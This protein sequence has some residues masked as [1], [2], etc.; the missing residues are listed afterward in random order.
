MNLRYLCFPLAVLLVLFLT[1]QNCIFSENKVSF[2]SVLKI[3]HF[4]GNGD[5][6]DGK[7]DPGDYVRTNPNLD[8]EQNQS[9]RQARVKVGVKTG[10]LLNDNCRQSNFEFPLGQSNVG[11][12]FYNPSYFT[13]SGAVFKKVESGSPELLNH[14]LCRF[15]DDSKGIDAIVTSNFSNKVLVATVLM[16][17]YVSLGVARIVHPNVSQTNSPSV[18]TFSSSEGFDLRI[19]GQP[20][21]YKNLSGT[22][23][24]PIDGTTKSYPVVCQKMSENPVLRINTA[25]LVAYWKFDVPLLRDGIVLEDSKGAFNGWLR[26]V[27]SGA[28]ANERTVIS[29]RNDQGGFGRG[30]NIMHMD[31]GLQGRI[32]DGTNLDPTGVVPLPLPSPGFHHFVVVYDRTAGIIRQFMDGV[33]MNPDRDISAFGSITYNGNFTIGSSDLPIR[34]YWGDLD[35]VSIWTRP[36]TQQDVQAIYLLRN[37]Y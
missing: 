9:H 21:D 8:C 15:K 31:S 4:E 1:S 32:S 33:Q 35:E 36:L 3:E 5:G 28:I 18:T 26:H 34:N 27:D 10:T 11:F 13:F 6:V 25:N 24:T 20:Q 12:E 2:N 22:L 7:P 17:N 16:G 23:T 37:L 30:W 19:Y 14:A 29:K